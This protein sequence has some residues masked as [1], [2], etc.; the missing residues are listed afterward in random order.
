MS[1]FVDT[2][3]ILL[4]AIIGLPLFWVCMI[5]FFCIDILVEL[6]SLP[7][8]IICWLCGKK[9]RSFYLRVE[10]IIAWLSQMEASL[11]NMEVK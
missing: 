7:Y 6:F 3:L 11:M 9:R 1:N 5:L 10:H 8:T 4:L 2:I